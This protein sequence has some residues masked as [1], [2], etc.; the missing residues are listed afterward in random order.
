M[1]RPGSYGKPMG[2]ISTQRWC[3]KAM[4]CGTSLRG[5]QVFSSSGE[6]KNYEIFLPAARK[7]FCM[8]TPY[9]STCHIA[10]YNFK[11]AFHVF[12]NHPQTAKSPCFYSLWEV[13]MDHKWVKPTQPWC[14]TTQSSSF[15]PASISA[16]WRMGPDEKPPV[17]LRQEKCFWRLKKKCIYLI[18]VLSRRSPLLAPGRVLPCPDVTCLF[19]IRNKGTDTCDMESFSQCP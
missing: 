19:A 5:R 11:G 16:L 13:V 4:S 15:S 6:R 3:M 18:P 14:R 8:Q 9:S 12:K 10:L 7:P 1:A 17:P 2:K